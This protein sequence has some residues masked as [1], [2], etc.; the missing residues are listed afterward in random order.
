A[1][2]ADDAGAFIVDREPPV[3][4]G[5][6]VPQP[7]P[8]ARVDLSLADPHGGVGFDPAADDLWIQ[9]E[10]PAGSGRW[11]DLFAGRRGAGDHTLALDISALSPGPHAARVRAVDALG[12]ASLTALDGSFVVDGD[13]PAIRQVRVA[14][15]SADRAEVAFVVDDGAAGTGVSAADPFTVECDTGV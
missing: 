7:H 12:Q 4:T 8:G 9:A 14:P 1:R 3:A 5:R 15:L 11:V 13:P 2:T 10:Q 6:A